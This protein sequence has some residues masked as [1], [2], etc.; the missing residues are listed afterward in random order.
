M[1][2][3]NTTKPDAKPPVTVKTPTGKLPV[4]VKTPEVNY[5]VTKC[6]NCIEGLISNGQLPS[7]DDCQTI[8]DFEVSDK[9][10]IYTQ[11]LIKGLRQGSGMPSD[12]SLNKILDA[13]KAD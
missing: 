5:P 8:L 3:E 10:V 13:L 7:K 6:T 12:K 4:T 1:P 11:E 9:G 2:D